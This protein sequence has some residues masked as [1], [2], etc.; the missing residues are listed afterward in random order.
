MSIPFGSQDCDILLNQSQSKTTKPFVRH[1]RAKRNKIYAVI[2]DS[3][4]RTV[5]VCFTL[6]LRL[7]N[8]YE[9]I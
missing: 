5:S 3:L 6:L 2:R 1:K 4:H 8:L 9:T 7:Q